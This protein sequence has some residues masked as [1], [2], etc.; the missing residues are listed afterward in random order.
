MPS[1]NEQ[2]RLVGIGLGIGD[3][4][5]ITLRALENLR[6][7]DLL[8]YPCTTPRGESAALQR[9]AHLLLE[10]LPTEELLFPML[11]EREALE[12]YWKKAGERVREEVDKGKQVG[13]ITIGDPL[14]YS[15]FGYLLEIMQQHPQVPVEVI[16][17][18]T[19]YQ[20]CAAR[21]HLPLVEG[22]QNMAVFTPPFSNSALDKTLEECSTVIIMKASSCLEQVRDYLKFQ[23][24]KM[25][26]PP[27]GNFSG[28]QAWFV[29]NCGG[30]KEYICNNLEELD[31]EKTGYMSLLILTRRKGN[32]M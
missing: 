13:F 4:G 16:P 17:G 10:N 12:E 24:Q 29:A 18:I 11:H 9:C 31:E 23:R 20:A 22:R 26:S 32:N 2:G 1:A 8:F 19:A 6:Q 5:N 21:V 14:F 15:T 25:S 28:M 7:L 30:E 27:E 3:P